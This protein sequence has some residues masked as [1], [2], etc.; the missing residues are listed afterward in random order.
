MTCYKIIS[1]D[2]SIY[3]P[4]T[5][6]PGAVFT[7]QA[8][9]RPDNITY[10]IRATAPMIH[11]CDNAFDTM[12]WHSYAFA[13]SSP[14]YEIKPLGQ[15]IKQQCDDDCRLYQCGSHKIEIVHQIDKHEMFERAVSEFLQNPKAK[16]A[17]YPNLQDKMPKI[18][19]AWVHHE[20]SKYVY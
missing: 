8:P 18:I 13:D 7:A 16:I 20:Q 6:V 4:D 14:I 3:N 17:M 5:L 12:L 2:T 19:S 9:L 15:V 1:N 11:F 10:Y